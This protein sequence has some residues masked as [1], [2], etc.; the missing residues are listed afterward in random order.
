M[1]NII[2]MFL[3]K[4]PIILSPEKMLSNS[5]FSLCHG[6][7]VPCFSHQWFFDNII[8][9]TVPTFLLS[10]KSADFSRFYIFP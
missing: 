10:H 4:F 9:D 6:N 3:G 1:L 7:P 8:I 5:L 2:L